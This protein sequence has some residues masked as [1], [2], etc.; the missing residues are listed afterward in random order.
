MFTPPRHALEAHGSPNWSESRVQSSSM[1]SACNCA[2]G[3]NNNTTRW[4]GVGREVKGTRRVVIT[5]LFLHSKP[6]TLTHPLNVH[7]LMHKLLLADLSLNRN[8]CCLLLLLLLTA[9][10]LRGVNYWELLLAFWKYPAH[11]LLRNFLLLLVPV[12]L[13]ISRIN[14]LNYSMQNN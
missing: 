5:A 11:A 13:Q 2:R 14:S 12:C 4:N 6:R 3:R 7:Y 1:R 8:S 9:A 10:L